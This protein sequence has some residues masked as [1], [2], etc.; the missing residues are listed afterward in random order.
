MGPLR[1]VLLLV[2]LMVLPH[3]LKTSLAALHRLK[4]LIHLAPLHH[5]RARK[6]LARRLGLV[7]VA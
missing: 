2:L 7:S 5:P 6:S 4:T 1:P 3:R